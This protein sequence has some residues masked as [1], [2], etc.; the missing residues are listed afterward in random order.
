[1][2]SDSAAIS[3][4]PPTVCSAEPFWTLANIAATC[5]RPS[6][7]AGAPPAEPH[8]FDSIPQAAGRTRGNT[9]VLCA[10]EPTPRRTQP[11]RQRRRTDIRTLTSSPDNNAAQRAHEK[12]RWRPGTAN[13]AFAKGGRCQT[14][15]QPLSTWAPGL[16]PT[17]EPLASMSTLSDRSNRP[18]ADTVN[19]YRE[20]SR[21]R[22]GRVRSLA[23]RVVLSRGGLVSVAPG[24]RAENRAAGSGRAIE[25]AC[26]RALFLDRDGGTYT[27]VGR[28]CSYPWRRIESGAASLVPVDR[29][30]IRSA[31]R[32][33][34]NPASPGHVEL[35]RTLRLTKLDRPCTSIAQNTASGERKPIRRPG[36][37]RTGPSD[38]RR[39]S[40]PAGRLWPARRRSGPSPRG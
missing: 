2:W 32:P 40:F 17:D 11:I 7:S 19:P 24:R 30:H 6:G 4:N 28:R 20:I 1:M 15:R 9:I 3:S 37:T 25:G 14:V 38:L 36:N 34:P 29:A 13:C 12:W 18:P 23:G 27:C 33:P 31:A 26:D 39:R 35:A 21:L 16:H 10:G 22:P 8:L 5:S